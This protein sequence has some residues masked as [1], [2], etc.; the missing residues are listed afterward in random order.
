MSVQAGESQDPLRIGRGAAAIGLDSRM[1]LRVVN[2][3][4]IDII[5]QRCLS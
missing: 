1:R 2:D 3:N 5:N 4:F